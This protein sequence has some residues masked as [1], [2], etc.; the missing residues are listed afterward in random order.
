MSIYRKFERQELRKKVSSTKKE[1]S[2]KGKRL[3]QF[4]DKDGKMKVTTIDIQKPYRKGD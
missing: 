1:L 3:V 2:K 4:K